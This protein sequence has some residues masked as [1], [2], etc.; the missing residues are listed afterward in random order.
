ML[1]VLNQLSVKPEFVDQLEEAFLEHLEGLAASPGFGGFRFL[2]PLQP[3]ESPCIVEVYW[4]DEAAFQAWKQ[5][6]NFKQS[7][8][9]LGRFREAFYAPPKF[10]HFQVSKDLPLKV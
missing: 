7:H 2:K 6:E 5:S 1:A 3:T 4:Q 8:A 9:Q 10:G